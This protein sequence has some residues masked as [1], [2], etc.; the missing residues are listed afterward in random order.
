MLSLDRRLAPRAE[1]TRWRTSARAGRAEAHIRGDAW[2]RKRDG[3]WVHPAPAVVY[4]ILQSE[5]DDSA[6]VAQLLSLLHG[7][8]RDELAMPKADFIPSIQR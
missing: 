2:S 1:A 8:S 5:S 7:R 3:V 4:E 6:V